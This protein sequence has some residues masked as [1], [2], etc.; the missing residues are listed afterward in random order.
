MLLDKSSIK[1]DFDKDQNKRGRR[2][3]N[4]NDGRSHICKFCGKSYLS[5]PALYTHTKIKHSSG[6]NSSG[7]SRGRPKKENIDG[8]INIYE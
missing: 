4:D 6:Q 1:S 2:S 5:Y 3:K 8:V 7:R